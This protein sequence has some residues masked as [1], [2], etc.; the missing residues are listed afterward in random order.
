MSINSLLTT[1]TL[2]YVYL[3]GYRE[4]QMFYDLHPCD[5]DLPY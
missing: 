5:L 4:Y 3:S 2:C 1:N